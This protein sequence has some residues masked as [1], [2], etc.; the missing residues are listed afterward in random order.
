M[1][2]SPKVIKGAFIQ[3]AQGL[4]SVEP[5]VVVFQYNPAKLTHALTPWNPFEG[6]Q[7]QRGAQ[8][9]NVQPFN[10]KETFSLV[11]EL[12]AADGLASGDPLTLVSGIAPQLA[13]LKKLTLPSQ[14]LLGDLVASA[15]A[16]V[17]AAAST[18]AVRPTVPILLFMWGPGLILP[19]R[20]TSFSIEISLFS[21]LL[22]PLQAS[23]TIAIEVLTPD[24]FKCRED[25]AVKIA[26]A[27]F[28]MTKT[29][30]DAMALLNI[31]NSAK[32]V[33]GMLPI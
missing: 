17:G 19:V 31:A 13:A 12:D 10:P 1:S 29:K 30:E 4:V 9:P 33:V 11:L 21:P 3:L 24:L 8:A 2:I 22:D 25:I 32:S 26:K 15:Q 16:L 14:G 7:A 5:N 20:I 6:D 18:N 28:N 23:V 27:A